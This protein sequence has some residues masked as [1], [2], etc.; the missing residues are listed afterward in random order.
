MMLSEVEQ[1]RK[2]QNSLFVKDAGQTGRALIKIQQEIREIDTNQ[3]IKFD[4]ISKKSSELGQAFSLVQLQH[5]L[6]GTANQ[7]LFS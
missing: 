5:H 6:I 7:V 2:D 4:E 3:K 1:S